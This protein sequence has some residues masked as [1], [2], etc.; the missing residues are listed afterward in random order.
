MP[1]SSPKK[2]GIRFGYQ[3][4]DGKL[5]FFVSDTGCGI[6]KRSKTAFSSALSKLDSFAQGTGLGLSISQMIVQKLGGDR[7]GI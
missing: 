5:L 1:S 6:D 2:A 3:H 7:R 4:K